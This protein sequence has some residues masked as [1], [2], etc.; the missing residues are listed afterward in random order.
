[1]A[2]DLTGANACAAGFAR[3]GFRSVTI[4]EGATRSD[5][6]GFHRR[7]DVVV[8]T[9]NARHWAPQ[10]VEDIVRSTV[11]AG[12]PVDLVACRID[13]TLR[14]N[15]GA[16]ANGLIAQVRQLSEERVVGL[17]Q[18]AYPQAGRVTVQGQQ[19]LYGKRLEDTELARD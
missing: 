8:V 14:G 9:T 7:F 4:E 12:W 19:L 16:A 10:A 3:A 5:I 1:I 15:I 13:T 18:P 2:D 11:R 17:C 6:A